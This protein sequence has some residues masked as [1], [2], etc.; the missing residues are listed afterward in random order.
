MKAMYDPPHPGEVL[1]ETYL[2]PLELTVTEAAKM[3]GIGRQALS[4]I[5]SG[6]TGVSVSMA[7]KL[8]KA[9][10]TTPQMWLNMQQLYD[11][12]QARKA[13]DTTHV[14]R[15][16]GISGQDEARFIT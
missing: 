5:I 6:H 4:S 15:F 1:M 9:C 12:W 13:V 10:N 2:G 16:P 7:V 14:R 8:A 3:L 11:L